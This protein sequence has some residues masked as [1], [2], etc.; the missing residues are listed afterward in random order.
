MGRNSQLKKNI[1]QLFVSTLL[2]AVLIVTV[3]IVIS[4]STTHNLKANAA[5]EYNP[6]IKPADFTH[7]ITNKYTALPVGKKMI[8]ESRTKDGLERI[9]IYISGDTKTVM[10]VN[11]LVYHDQVW[12][13]GEFLEDTRDYLAQDKEGNVWYFGEDVDNYE[14]GVIADHEGSWLAGVDGAKP[15]YW[16]KANPVVGE[17]YRQEY[18]KGQAEDMATVVSLNERVV[19]PDGNFTGCLKT[20]DFSPL[21]P[22]LQEYKYYCPQVGA[23]ALESDLL[24]KDKTK[25]IDVLINGVSAE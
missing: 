24:S 4:K 11:T 15:G 13:N 18:Y 14:N 19:V 2:G 8:Y 20:Y 1:F 10:G 25:L 7:I 5:E 16:I 21:D 12:I 9:E 17:T 22:D 6:Q 23:M 3:S